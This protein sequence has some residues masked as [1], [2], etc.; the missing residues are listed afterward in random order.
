VL[1]A[2]SLSGES[3]ASFKQAARALPGASVVRAWSDRV[4]HVVTEPIVFE[5]KQLACRT[6]KHPCAILSGQWIV[7]SA[8]LQASLGRGCWLPEQ[9]YELDGDVSTRGHSGPRKGREAHAA[10]GAAIFQNT[11]V[12]LHGEC[13]HPSPSEQQLLA[14]LQLGGASV[15]ATLNARRAA[16]RAAGLQRWR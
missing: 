6:L 1:R 16:Q 14:L 8:W 4:T 11:R 15:C 2:S 10:G 13:V 12:Y 9:P 7:S 5:G 3:A